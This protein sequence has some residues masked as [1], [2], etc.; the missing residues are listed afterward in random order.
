VIT[1]T[2]KDL[3]LFNLQ[4]I[5]KLAI[6]V[7]AIAVVF[8][9][10]LFFEALPK[11]QLIAPEPSTLLLDRHQEFLAELSPDPDRGS[12]FWPLQ[13]WPERVINATLALEDKN[14]WQ[15]HGV[16]FS[17][18]FRALYQNLS[19]GRRIS[20]ASTIAMQIARMQNPGPRTYYRKAV[21]SLTALL[22]TAKY[23]RKQIISHYLTLVPYGNQIFGI[24]YA[25]ERYF[26][27]TL[28][29]LSWAEIALL[30]AIPQ[31]PTLHNPLRYKGK[32]LAKERAKRILEQLK[33]DDLIDAAQFNL[34]IHQL[35]RFQF[36]ALQKRPASAMHA[37]LNIQQQLASS[38]NPRVKHKLISSLDLSL[39]DQI[40]QLAKGY[41]K[42]WQA[43]GAENVA[44]LLVKN[45][46]QEV[47]TWL[48]SAD[49]FKS[50]DGAIDFITNPRSP[51]STLKPFIYGLALD[52]ELIN[53]GSLLADLP[54]KSQGLNNSDMRFLGPM[55]PRQ[56]LANSRNVPAV[57][58]LKQLGPKNAYAFFEQLKLHDGKIS[59]NNYGAGM[60][61]GTL[62]TTL[63]DLV[64]A[65]GV[66]ANDGH[67]NELQWYKND[68]VK[69]DLFKQNTANSSPL[70]SPDITRL[71]TLFLSDANARLPSFPRMG[72][73]EYQLPIAVK[74][75]TSQGY[76]D[77]WTLAYSK[78]YTVGVW[79]GRS[80]SRPMRKLGGA[81]SAA[82]LA[83]TIM[84][85]IHGK[86]EQFNQQSLAFNK[87]ENFQPYNICTYTGELA[88]DLCHNTVSEW[89]PKHQQPKIDSS[90]QRLWIDSRNRL[91]AGQWTPKA[92]L[93]QHDF[94]NLAMLYQ[95]WGLVNGLLPSPQAYSPLD[96]PDPEF[97]ANLVNLGK[98]QD[99]TIWLKIIT[100][101]N[102]QHLIINPNLPASLNTLA[103]NVESNKKVPQVLWYVNNKPLALKD[104]PYSIRW[105]LAVGRYTIRA[106]IPYY[107]VSSQ[108]VTVLV[109]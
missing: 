88:T 36:K 44:V 5:K 84:Q 69:S 79:V 37:I 58:L 57:N 83:R 102:N 1:A 41:L 48:G 63:K 33:Q 15:H 29:D 39:Q 4:A 12:G 3:R 78:Q 89:F 94:V 13:H 38:V 101:E 75:G 81:A 70:L 20:G 67:W 49:Y 52:K 76:R 28:M 9:A 40:Q 86:T 21:E 26:N 27:K 99:E 19:N 92:Y 73:L 16:D 59:A 55:L 30:S 14:F 97:H 17:A 91:L 95:Q 68:K 87:P 35:Q 24:S 64:S 32:R 7:V 106:E 109:Q 61:I 46:T 10:W 56:A 23:S 93:Q 100:P 54:S 104:F 25:A 31:A 96:N 60:A 108:S 43:S 80:D 53:P 72:T 50:H 98:A 2:H 11:A 18:V 90:H 71:I 34:A 74:T 42:R 22:I 66:L 45:D 51:G 62:P 85:I 47:I 65:Y 77:A 6:A 105:P 107:G 103:L 82:V 8:V